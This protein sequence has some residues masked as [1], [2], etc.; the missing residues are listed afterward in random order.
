LDAGYAAL[1]K[2][3]VN[4]KHMLLFADGSD[5][6][7]M[8][9]CEAKVAGAFTRGITTSVVALGNGSDV[10]ALE[11]LSRLGS[12]R[13]YLVE[14]ATRLPAVFAQETILAS[15]SAIVEKDFKVA[16][17][18]GS[19]ITAGVDVDAAPPLHG[20]VVTLPKGRASVLLTGPESDPILAVWSAGVGRAA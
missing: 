13:F 11:K 1:D 17:G 18:V 8:T 9:G 6:E 2:Q 16:R 10:P 3:K 12:G 4:L 19:S 20:Y 7:E 15:R 5:A 14:N